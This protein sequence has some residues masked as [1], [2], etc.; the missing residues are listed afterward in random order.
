MLAVVTIAPLYIADRYLA[1]SLVDTNPWTALEKVE[2]A[3]QFNPVHPRIAQREAELAAQIGDWTRVEE[4][5]AREI[6]LNPE[7]YIPY[8]L[9]A[10][11]YEQRSQTE[12]ALSM[13]QRALERNPLE[14]TLKESVSRLQRQ[15]GSNQ[16]G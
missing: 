11:F 14:P 12:E 15:N 1:Q 6:H 3:Q 9:L 7:H 16:E 8:M 5:Y 10:Q 4:A 13:Y 2:Q